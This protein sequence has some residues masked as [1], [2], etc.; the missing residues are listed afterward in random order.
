LFRFN[1]LKQTILLALT[2][3]SGLAATTFT[4]A[5][6]GVTLDYSRFSI[7]N[8]IYLDVYLMIPQSAFTYTAGE[9]GVESSVIFQA[10]LIQ[11]DL[12]PYPPDRWQ[13]IYRAENRAAVSGLSY[14]PDISKFYVE[15]GE[16]MLQVDII[17]VNSNRRQR[18]R[19]P[20]KLQVFPNDSLSLSDITIASQIVKT[21]SENEFTKYG[22]DVV[23]NAGRI[24][25]PTAPML[26]YF[27]EVYG[28]SGTGNYSLATQILSLNGDLVQEYPLQSKSMPGTT[29]VEWGGINTAGLK[30]GIHQLNIIVT[31]EGDNQVASTRKTFYVIRPQ[32][33]A[34]TA[35]VGSHEYDALNEAQLDAIYELVSIVMEK[36]EQNLFQQSDE[37]GKRRVL[38]TFWERKDPNP[39]TPVNEFKTAFYQRVQLANREFGTDRDEG[40]KTD[41]GRVLIQYGQPD[42]IERIP[43]SLDQKPW[44]TWS[45]YDI[46]GGVDFIFVDRTGYGSFQLVHSTALDEVQDSRWQ[47]YLK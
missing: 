39:D 8:G 42:N 34:T 19:K 11:D 41:R 27:F 32:S 28:L 26:Y 18:I 20:L 23:P 17:D 4:D 30:S 25:S 45:Y 12:V 44:E 37:V 1:L 2:L 38:S 35:T 5:D 33:A 36:S 16:Y 43:S 21:G 24:F 14:V 9:Q 22:H 3:A 29:A 40:W 7:K 46:Q 13:R 10:A 47:R 6:L 15:P 31:D